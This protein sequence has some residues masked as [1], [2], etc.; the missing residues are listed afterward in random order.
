MN[1]IFLISLIIVNNL[2]IQT[3]GGWNPNSLKKSN[4]IEIVKI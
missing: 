3:S 1:K 2:F 4:N